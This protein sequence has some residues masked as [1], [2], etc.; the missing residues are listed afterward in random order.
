[1]N[2]GT[3]SSVLALEDSSR[4]LSAL[5]S[6][7]RSDITKRRAAA[8]LSICR[9]ILYLSAHISSTLLHVKD[10]R[11]LK[12]HIVILW[13][14]GTTWSAFACALVKA[15][16]AVDV[17][18]G[19]HLLIG[20]TLALPLS[21]AG[22]MAL[23]SAACWGRLL[24]RI[25]LV[26]SGVLLELELASYWCQR[27]VIITIRSIYQIIDLKLQHA[28]ALVVGHACNDSTRLINAVL[29]RFAFGSKLLEAIATWT[30][31]LVELRAHSSINV[32]EVLMSEADISDWAVR[33]HK[34]VINN[35]S[36][37][38]SS[39]RRNLWRLVTTT[40]R[41][42]FQLIHFALVHGAVELLDLINEC[43]V[44]NDCLF[45]IVYVLLLTSIKRIVIFRGRSRL[46]VYNRALG[47]DLG[48]RRHVQRPV[49]IKV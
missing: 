6:C 22:V 9:L 29:I 8:P 35:A 45:T 25:S 5:V 38:N 13:R 23:S 31:L 3:W 2:Q 32:I 44:I 39:S 28:L 15:I 49:C 7:W 18:Q 43:L 42:V 17:A 20:H 12:R 34:S 10:T 48:R 26:E 21:C 46:G 16:I 24:L 36:S 19:L 47:F 37:C 4:G 30:N 41:L 33:V 27:E 1:M 40:L 11:C 14:Q